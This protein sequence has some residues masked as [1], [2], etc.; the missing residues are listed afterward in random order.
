[1]EKNLMQW[2][3]LA[4]LWKAVLLLY[5][6]EFYLESR[7]AG[8]LQRNAL[9][10]IFLRALE[11]YQGLLFLTTNR[12]GT[13]D[14]A[15]ISRIHVFLHYPNFSNAQRQNIWSTSFRKLE[16]ERPDI[17]LGAGLTEYALKN[18]ELRKLEWNGCE[19]RN[20]CN[21]IVALVV[22]DSKKEW[23]LKQREEDSVVVKVE[24]SH[25]KQVLEMSDKFKRYMD[26]TYLLDLSKSQHVLR[27]R[28]G[29]KK[30]R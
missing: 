28:D 22:F 27:L 1:M 24:R 9:V 6:A 12:V 29:D 13:F 10:S 18:E 30:Q 7:R 21:M 11:Y 5:E 25:L 14:E 2:L 8:N 17:K 16:E 15:M 4:T 3:K 26:Q 20:A 19:A 23:R